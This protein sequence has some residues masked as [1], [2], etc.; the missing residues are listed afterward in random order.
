MFLTDEVLSLNAG[1]AVHT[2]LLYICSG[3]KLASWIQV[4]SV[5]IN[6]T[7]V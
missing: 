6:R 4:T 7:R 1:V 3:W 2:L 5:S